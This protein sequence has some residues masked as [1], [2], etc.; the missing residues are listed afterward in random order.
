MNDLPYNVRRIYLLKCSCFR[1][2]SFYSNWWWIYSLILI[3]FSINC[4]LWLS[5]LLLETLTSC[6]F[7]FIYLRI[8]LFIL[9][10]LLRKSNL[11]NK[12]SIDT[13]WSDSIL[14]L[15]SLL[16]M[17]IVLGP[18]NYLKLIINMISGFLKVIWGILF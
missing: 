5:Q 17:I 7:I 1:T 8:H 2:T 6:H 9:F 15:S 18:S 13:V 4:C 16:F 11:T 3:F 12:F 14:N 10:S